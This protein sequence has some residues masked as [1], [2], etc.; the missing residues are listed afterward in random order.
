MGVDVVRALSCKFQIHP[1]PVKQSY[2]QSGLLQVR[3]G[4]ATAQFQ[5]RFGALH[6]TTPNT[7]RRA[8]R[9]SRRGSSYKDSTVPEHTRRVRTILRGL[10]SRKPNF[11]NRVSTTP[12]QQ[13]VRPSCMLLS[14]HSLHFVITSTDCLLSLPLCY[15]FF[16]LR[17][18][19]P[20][21]SCCSTAV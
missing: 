1:S 21:P 7:P 8:R 19:S 6:P 12:G 20:S 5:A 17:P 13:P 14:A 10:G 3:L 15:P 16:S 4:D 2:A 9:T 18:G 11:T